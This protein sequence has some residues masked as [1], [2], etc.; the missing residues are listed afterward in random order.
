MFLRMLEQLPLVAL[1]HNLSPSCQQAHHLHQAA[2][3][4]QPQTG[5]LLPQLRHSPNLRER[6]QQGV[7]MQ[8]RRE[9]ADRLELERL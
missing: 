5:V 8:L 3:C 2:Q 6:N 1:Q 4:L 9:Q 7:G